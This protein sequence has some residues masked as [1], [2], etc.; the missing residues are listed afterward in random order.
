MGVRLRWNACQIWK[1]VRAGPNSKATRVQ[2]IRLFY[3]E[4]GMDQ[5][6]FGNCKNSEVRSQHDQGLLLLIQVLPVMR[7]ADTVS[8]HLQPT[9]ITSHTNCTIYCLAP[10]GLSGFVSGCVPQFFAKYSQN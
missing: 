8:F 2:Y 10:P 9:F 3:K 4:G 7:A 5:L 6:E 1:R